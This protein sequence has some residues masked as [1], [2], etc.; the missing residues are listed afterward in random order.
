M[1]SF[2]KIYSIKPN[3]KSK[4]GQKFIMMI[5]QKFCGKT[6]IFHLSTFLIDARKIS[7]K[8]YFTNF[9]LS[10]LQTLAAGLWTWLL[11]CE[12]W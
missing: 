5:D 11:E 12:E 4:I 6:H 1:P 8:S 3:S 9:F 10:K 7:K 2:G